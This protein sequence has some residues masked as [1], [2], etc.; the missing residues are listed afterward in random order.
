MPD[1]VSEGLGDFLD[2]V[3]RETK[4][5]VYLEESQ[6][7]LEGVE[8][9]IAAVV[10]TND[11]ATREQLGKKIESALYKY[12]SAEIGRRPMIHAVVK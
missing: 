4:G 8:E 11:K 7:L 1:E 6:D 12:F 9:T 2:T 5:F 3:W 10:N